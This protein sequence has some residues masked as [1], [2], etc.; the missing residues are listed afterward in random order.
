V[1]L[2]NWLRQ[3]GIVHT[4][5]NVITIGTHARRSRLLCGKAFGT[6]CKIGIICLEDHNYDPKRWWESSAGVRAVIGESIGYVYAR[7]FFTPPAQ[8]R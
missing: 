1:A 5:I 6:G 3:H 8:A 7:L 2:K 4:N